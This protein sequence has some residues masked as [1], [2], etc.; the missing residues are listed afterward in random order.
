MLNRL[1][2]YFKGFFKDYGCN[3]WVANV[4][5]TIPLII[6]AVLDALLLDDKWEYFWSS[7]GYKIA[8]YNLIFISL[9]NYLPMLLQISSLIFGFVRQK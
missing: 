7:G 8:V 6:R 9:V 2:V 3:L 1:R 4:L 5:L